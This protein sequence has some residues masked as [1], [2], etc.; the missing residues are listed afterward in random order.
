MYQSAYIGLRNLGRQRLRTGLTLGMI[1]AG[2]LLLVLAAGLAEGTYDEMIAVATEGSVGH[3]QALHEGYNE[4]PSLYDTIDDPDARIRELAAHP[5]VAALTSR[6]EAGGLVSYENQT[7]GVILIGVDPVQEKLVTRMWETVKEGQWLPPPTDTDQSLPIVI[8]SGVAS[9]LRVAL[10]DVIS[11]VGQGADGS[12]AAELFTIT[13]IFSTG[14]D[15]IDGGAV[16]V[17]LADAQELLVLQGRVH[18]IVGAVN[19][20]HQLDA[21]AKELPPAPGQ[22][23]LTWE[24]LIP[25]LEQSIT[26]DRNGQHVFLVI[27]VLVV[28]L[29][30]MNTMMM[31]ILERRREFGMLMALGTTPREMAA[32]TLWEAIWLSALGVAAAIL[33]GVLLNLWV[34]IPYP[35]GP[36]DFG[37]VTLDAMTPRNNL[38]GNLWYPLI[39]FG[40]T[41]V[42][43]VVP[44]LRASRLTPAEALRG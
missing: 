16:I 28:A 31:A 18:R 3:F 32:M 4:S 14:A 19:S 37:G 29:G 15:E 34:V 35:G 39:I 25:G 5:Q 36:I 38:R 44:A 33:A 22:E 41:L 6:V 7:T 24:T 11:F 42:V 17:R 13:G 10:G 40:T 26:V 20:L 1:F 21:V 8:G 23:L 12:L 9:R 2:T 43:S 27:I 30:V